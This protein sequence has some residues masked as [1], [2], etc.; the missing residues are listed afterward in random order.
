MALCNVGDIALDAESLGERGGA[1]HGCLF[2]F[3]PSQK[4]LT[5][6]IGAVGQCVLL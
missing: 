1:Q 4:N 3:T 2:S 6:E 5:G